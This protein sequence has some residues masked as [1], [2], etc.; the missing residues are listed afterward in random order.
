MKS[1]FLILISFLSFTSFSQ[2]DDERDTQGRDFWLTFMPNAHV[3][4]SGDI[5]RTRDSL[6]IFMASNVPTNVN[7]EY[8]NGRGET[9]N[10]TIQITDVFEYETFKLAWYDFELP[11]EGLDRWNTGFDY[12]QGNAPMS[13][14]ITSDEKITVIAH[15][16]AQWSSDGMIIYPTPTL[17]QKYFVNSYNSFTLQNG[18]GSTDR[19]S[20][21]AIVATEDNTEIIIRPKVALIETGSSTITTTLN[22]GE[23]YL[24]QADVQ[25]S[26]IADLTGSLIESDKP[27]AVFSG[28]ERAYVPRAGGGSKD[29][30]TAQMIPFESSGKRYILLP[31][32]QPENT[33]PLDSYQDLFRVLAYYDNTEIYI[34]GNLIE[35]LNEGE[36]YEGNIL[37]EA[38]IV[39]ANKTI[40]VYQLKKSVD[41]GNSVAQI[42]GDPFMLLNVA[43]SQFY[44]SYKVI[45]FQAQEGN[46]NGSG[47][48][49]FREVYE[50]QFISFAI[51][52]D[53]INTVLF[54]F[55]PL[56]P[57]IQFLEIP[58][59]NYVYTTLEVEIGTHLLT[60]EVG[61]ACYAYG[62][63]IANSYGFVGGGLRLR[64]LDHH[65]PEKLIIENDCYNERGIISDTNYLDSGIDRIEIL[66]NTNINFQYDINNDSLDFVPYEATLVD[67]SFDGE[68]I[69]RAYDEFGLWI[70]DTI[71]ISAFTI[72]IYDTANSSV[73][74]NNP[75]I[76][77]IEQKEF[78]F[79]INNYG[80]FDIDIS[81]IE[82][83]EDR[84]ELINDIFPV[85]VQPGDFYSFNFRFTPNNETEIFTDEIFVVSRCESKKI[86]DV[87]IETWTDVDDPL[88]TSDI[89]ENCIGEYN[90]GFNLEF[91]DIGEFQFGLVEVEVLQSDNVNIVQNDNFPD[92]A[93]I[94]GTLINPMIDGFVRIR[95]EDLVGNESIFEETIT[96]ISVSIGESLDPEIDFG[97]ITEGTVACE[98]IKIENYGSE[99][100]IIEEQEIQI[101]DI[102]SIP[103]AQFP[104]ILQPGEFYD[105]LVCFAPQEIKD[106]DE[107]DLA[108]IKIEDCLII[109]IN[110]KGRAKQ[111][112]SISS[113]RCELSLELFSDEVP[114]FNF[115][116]NAYPNPITGGSETS[117]RAGFMEDLAYEMELFT[118][119]GDRV[120]LLNNGIAKVGI[121]E[122]NLRF[123]DLE[124]GSYFL[125]FRSNSFVETMP[126]IIEK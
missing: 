126:I 38:K 13:F 72:E 24:G 71:Q 28:N 12:L 4:G 113:S 95:S 44:N 63:G 62:Y 121:N 18:F 88:L 30:L 53:Y 10:E 51:D 84:V 19:S 115:I 123:K 108:K 117:F 118:Y 119:T 116:D 8:T 50:R 75:G 52:K 74:D 57:S 92:N 103:S 45:N 99:E 68:I 122:F 98:T 86:G 27:I 46:A 6:Y 33:H 23:V 9:F 34:D 66:S 105:L 47:G 94:T 120:A 97:E 106:E 21:F 56:D 26:S 100:R 67:N 79:T 110:M 36:F 104:I 70:T 25:A 107:I 54:D 61:F 80:I 65:A 73:I 85:I 15:N 35:I 90:K 17:G 14:H 91:T 39:E 93:N 83:N 124:N 78:S 112:Q 16:Q 101:N 59:S 22:R 60:A 82:Y 111:F 1:I 5:F 76:P 2:E 109:D 89:F 32:I 7:I 43:E 40:S 48:I 125:V 55:Q 64:L 29:Y 31:F 41:Y 87:L 11:D 96:G 37:D 102:F 77:I 49:T 58:N 42:L 81:G 69:Y 114:N 20:Q 3:S